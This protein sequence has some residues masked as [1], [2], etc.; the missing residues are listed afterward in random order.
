[1]PLPDQSNGVKV[2]LGSLVMPQLFTSAGQL[3]VQVPYDLPANTQYQVTVQRDSLLSVPEP[4]VVASAAPGIFTLN[5]TGSGAG[6][7][8]KADGVTLIQPG[9]PAKA[10]DTVL[11]YCTGL[12]PV[13]PSVP[14]GS[15]APS[16]PLA[17]TVNPVTV[18]IGG[19]TTTPI[20]AGLTPGSA[21]LYQVNVVVPQGIAAS[22]AVPVTLTVA[23]QTSPPVTMAVQ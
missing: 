7:I 12:G 21:G 2:F 13:S 4:L 15:P 5:Q 18:Q 10:G 19:Q 3:N 14:V 20:F 6:I 11:I 23:G 1:L 17:R 22:D 16:S 9:T 8:L